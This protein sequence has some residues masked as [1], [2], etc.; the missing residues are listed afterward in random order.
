M[1]FLQ[2]RCDLPPQLKD[3]WWLLDLAFLRDL[4]AKL[5]E[6]NTE[7]QDENKTII[8]MTSTTDSFKGTLQVLKIQLIKGVLTHFPSVQSRAEGPAAASVYILCIDK[9][10]RSLKVDLKTLNTQ[11]PRY[12]SILPV[13]CF[14]RGM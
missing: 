12:L 14:K 11:S 5:H 6:L 7:L 10:L 9:L 4:T 3:S 1:E 13:T 8:K 2:D